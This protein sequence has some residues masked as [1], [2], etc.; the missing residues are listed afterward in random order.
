MS[1]PVSRLL[2]AVLVAACLA[3]T[4]CTIESPLAV[5]R[6]WADYNTLCAPAVYY[7]T[8]SRVP[9]DSARVRELRWLYNAGP[10]DP[11]AISPV[12]PTRIL[13]SRTD[14]AMKVP[15]A[16][17]TPLP[18]QPGKMDVPNPSVPTGPVAGQPPDSSRTALSRDA[19]RFIH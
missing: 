8:T 7:Q 9:I 15:A 14:G 16:Q 4:G 11:D 2:R 10:D 19:W 17:S 3:V 1:R 12:P 5:R 18:P 6:V 13:T